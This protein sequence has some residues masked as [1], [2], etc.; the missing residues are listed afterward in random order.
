MEK[1]TKAKRRECNLAKVKEC[2]RRHFVK[3]Q[4]ANLEK[5]KQMDI[6]TKTKLRENNLE[7]VRK[8]QRKDFTYKQANPE[9]V[10]LTYKRNRARLQNIMGNSQN[11]IIYV[12]GKSQNSK[13]KG[14][15][16]K[17]F[18]VKNKF[19]QETAKPK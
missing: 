3:Y 7:G 1:Q 6:K 10:Q 8:R 13:Q 19:L 14:K 11:G 17:E 2:Q 12:Q 9:K 18:E 4:E 5:V 16:A 15:K